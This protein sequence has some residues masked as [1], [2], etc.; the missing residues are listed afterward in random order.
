MTVYTDTRLTTDCA[1]RLNGQKP[2]IVVLHHTAGVMS[3]DAL[4]GMMMPGGRTVSAH[5]AIKDR[6]IVNVVPE[7]KRA[8]ALGDAA[9]D[10]RALNA[11]CINSTGGPK[12]ELSDATHESIARWVAD[13]CKRHGI[14]PHREGPQRSWTVIGHREVHSIHGAGYA[15]ACPGGMRLGWI[16]ERAQTIL[17]Q[18][19]PRPKP[20]PTSKESSMPT[21][22]PLVLGNPP[23][24]NGDWAMIGDGGVVGL[25]AKEDADLIN[26]AKRAMIEGEPIYG[27]QADQL[28]ALFARVAL[29]PTAIDYTKLAA[30]IVKHLPAGATADAIADEL[31]ARLKA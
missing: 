28:Q 19:T 9:F 6:E 27:A 16:V 25:R 5:A 10:S 21:F 12:W 3:I 29:K 7:S 23:R 4:V 2:N 26:I 24:L 15:T 18:N 31:A 22:V 11:E 20:K 8:Y 13:V 14:R 17:E 30:E 1:P